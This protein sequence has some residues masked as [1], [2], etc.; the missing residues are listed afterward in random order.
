MIIYFMIMI[1]GITQMHKNKVV[2]HINIMKGDLIPFTKK[3]EKEKILQLNDNS[4]SDLEP[5]KCQVIN[6]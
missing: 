4:P 2:N 5:L 3:K 1:S 6:N